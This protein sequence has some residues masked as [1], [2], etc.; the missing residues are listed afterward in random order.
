MGGG[1]LIGAF[2]DWS[3]ETTE[4]LLESVSGILLRGAPVA[5]GTEETFSRS[6]YFS[7]ELSTHSI[8][9]SSYLL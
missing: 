5:A 8:S 3:D 7:R 6:S 9:P 2:E 4:D 1:A